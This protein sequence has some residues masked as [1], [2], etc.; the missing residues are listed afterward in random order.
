M[1]IEA[2]VHKRECGGEEGHQLGYVVSLG[3]EFLLGMAIKRFVELVARGLNYA[4]FFGDDDWVF[5]VNVPRCS[6]G[7]LR[8]EQDIG[9]VV[10]ETRTRLMEGHGAVVG[11]GSGS[12]SRVHYE[13]IRWLIG[14]LI[15]VVVGWS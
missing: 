3:F 9:V 4:G 1:G 10:V 14:L 5:G 11:F 7:E 2:D 13:W 15:A 12:S 6:C 8:F